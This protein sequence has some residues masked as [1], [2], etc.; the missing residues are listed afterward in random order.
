[1]II[2]SFLFQYVE[3][4]VLAIIGLFSFFLLRSNSRLSKQNK[5]LSSNL[6]G[7]SQIIDI[8]KKV[9]DVAKNN[10]RTKLNGNITRMRK[11]EL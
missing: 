10:K 8:Q 7:Q 9:I 2:F 4:I 11:D 1:M 6:Q 3:R 5:T